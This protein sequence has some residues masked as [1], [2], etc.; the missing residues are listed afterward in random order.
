M[1]TLEQAHEC[2]GTSEDNNAI[3]QPLLQALP[4]YI[5]TTTGMSEEQQRG[6]SLVDTV[7]RL[8]LQS[9]YYSGHEEHYKADKAQ[10]AI[11]SLL[12]ALTV[13]AR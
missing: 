12:K 4:A 3:V 9:W 8:L 7:G 2:L 6:V 1:L 10:L 5:E 11:D 13:M